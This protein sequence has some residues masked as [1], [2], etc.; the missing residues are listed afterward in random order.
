MT[1]EASSVLYS[2]INEMGRNRIRKEINSDIG[3]ATKICEEILNRIMAKLEDRADE[4]TL[5]AICEGLLHFMLTVSLLPSQRKL[6]FRGLELDI[7]VPSTRLLSTDPSKTLVIQVLKKSEEKKIANAEQLQPVR[8]N[9][10]LVSA[11]KLSTGYRNYN[12]DDHSYAKIVADI[13]AFVK[14]KGIS[15]LSLMHGE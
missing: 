11:S 13:Q 2:V 10:W 7:A 3:L 6:Q 5:T 14:S 15:G 1:I 12:L 9:I 4:E 8:A